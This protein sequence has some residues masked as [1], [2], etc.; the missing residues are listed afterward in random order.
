MK[1]STSA[2]LFAEYD[3]FPD[4][5]MVCW[6]LGSSLFGIFISTSTYSRWPSLFVFFLQQGMSC[7]SIDAR[8]CM[9]ASEQFFSF[10]GRTSNPCGSKA[11]L[12]LWLSPLLWLSSLY[13]HGIRSCCLHVFVQ[14]VS[15]AIGVGSFFI[16]KESPG[17][18]CIGSQASQTHTC[19]A[20]SNRYR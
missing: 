6:L 9:N 3:R 14:L 11:I 18:S 20:A 5:G 10:T 1:F 12:R 8:D 16:P 17:Q 15:S 13:Q 19:R 2:L 7:T 4:I